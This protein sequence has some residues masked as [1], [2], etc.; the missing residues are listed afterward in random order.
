MQR[1]KTMTAARDFICNS[2]VLLTSFI[3]ILHFQVSAQHADSS[4]N[5]VRLRN[6]TTAFVAG[7]GFSIVGM[8]YLWYKD[9]E[10]Q[11][12]QFFNDNAEWKQ[13]DKL[14]HFYSSFYLSALNSS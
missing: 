2:R 7:Y 10:K 13:V 3:L 12:F 1:K 11:S 6:Y 4:V 14:G 9:S 8:H 5:K